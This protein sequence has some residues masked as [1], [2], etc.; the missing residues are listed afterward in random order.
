MNDPLVLVVVWLVAVVGLAWASVEAVWWWVVPSQGATVGELTGRGVAWTVRAVVALLTSGGVQGT[1]VIALLAVAWGRFLPFPAAAADPAV[2]LL[3]ARSPWLHDA[4]RLWYYLAPGVA[5]AGTWALGRV[6]LPSRGET[7]GTLA[8][9]KVRYW[10]AA[11]SAALMAEGVQRPLLVSALGLVWWRFLPFPGPGADPVVGLL[12]GRSPLLHEAVRTWHYLAPGVALVGSWG[13]IRGVGRVWFE[14]HR[15][16][17]GAGRL[18]GWPLRPS[19][20]APALVLGE[21]HHPVAL[22]EVERPEWLVVP[23]RGLFTGM[24]IVGAV[25]SGKTS[26]CMRPFAKQLLSWQATDPDRRMAGLV[27]EVKGDFCHQVRDVLVG[28]GRSQDYVELGLGGRWSW[29]PL[30]AHWLD[31]YSLAYTIAS[32]INQLFGRGHEPFWQQAYTNLV[33]WVIELHRLQPGGWVTLQDVYRCTIDAERIKSLLSDAQ[34]TVT[35]GTYVLI[36]GR[37]MTAH[38]DELKQAFTSSKKYRGDWEAAWSEE[39]EAKL[40][41]LKVDYRVD[42]VRRGDPAAQK[43]L[44]AVRRWFEQDWS[45]L[46]KKVATTIVEG[47]SVFLSVFDLPEI[48]DVFCPDN[49]TVQAVTGKLG[50]EDDGGSARDIGLDRRPLP[51]LDE[52]IESGKVLALNMPA[53]TNAALARAVGVMLKQSWLH[54]L[55]RRPA[56]MQKDPAR[57][58]RPAMFL[59]DEYQAFATVGED[60][61]SGDEKAFALTRQCRLVPIVATQSISSLRAVL[62]QGEAWRALLQTL[63]TRVFL[64]LSDD[65]SAQMASGLC[66]QVARMKASYTVSEQTQRA[67]A[68]V[69]TGAAGGGAGSVGAS[70]A[71]SEKREPLFHPRD[72]TILGNCQAIVQAYDGQQ[73][74]DA[75]RCYLK[76]DFLPRDVS[77]WRHRDAGKI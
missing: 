54:T 67:S 47:L 10:W 69:L 53:G 40:R 15:L 59:C 5:L 65:A 45:K 2:G 72:F 50:V 42:Q 29:N 71:F 6:W 13:L 20:P 1:A 33:R 70:K 49:P 61:P 35:G 21:V 51:P 58:F 14:S 63:R 22:R 24:L 9:R 37:T 56:A 30:G 60:D 19:D 36:A 7:V 62:G 38:G 48:A 66:G 75:T 31:S 52:V 3:A 41:E 18:P 39:I 46:D 23:E 25:G 64:S 73:S 8:R 27:L 16:R 34:V 74:H 57:V 12:A 76:P 28:A 77:Y 43:R 11:W 17:A 4:V 55:L 68:S 32:L 26:A 44:D